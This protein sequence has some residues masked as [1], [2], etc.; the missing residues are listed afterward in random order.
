MS[1]LHLLDRLLGGLWG[2]VTGDALG[3]P[4]EFQDRASL[5]RNP[6]TGMRAFGTHR[7]PAGTWSD[8][9]SLLLCSAES[10]AECGEFNAA[11]LAQRFIRWERHA[12][13]SPHGDVF[14]IGVATS[15]A[16]GRLEAGVPPELAGGADVY[17]NGN[18]SLMRILPNALAF[19]YHPPEFLAKIAQRSSSLT[20]RHPRSQMACAYY[21]LFAKELVRAKTPAEALARTNATFAQLYAQE[22]FHS[23]RMN[24]QLLEDGRLATRKEDEIDSSGYVMHTLTA[25][26]WCLLTSTSY[27]ETVLKAV[28]L[29]GDTD[30]TGTVAGG[31][32]GLLYGLEAIPA[33]WRHQLARH[34]DLASLFDRFLRPF[35][36][37]STS[38]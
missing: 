17:D 31:L 30:T 38:S 29:G 11:D 21:C 8:D 37:V 15:S 16:I 25:S 2:A 28:N 22:P 3:V 7:Q 1:A 13:W 12:Y 36:P 27:E 14:D 5:R 24:F 32:A 10:L 34:D 33:E 26:I 4:V 20:H 18:G 19:Y 9:S 35:L 23:E 6:V